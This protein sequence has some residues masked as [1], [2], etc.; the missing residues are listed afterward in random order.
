MK[1][2]NPNI[3]NGVHTI[4][5]TLQQWDYVGHIIQ[6]MYGNCMGRDVLDFEFYDID[7]APD[8]DCKLKY[9]EDYDYFTCVLKNENGDTLK[10]EGDTDE[11]NDMIVG[12]EIIDFCER[13]SEDEQRNPF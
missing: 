1:N 8:N 5:I 2:Y 6:K 10:C 9:H 7:D 12:I 13:K 11:M 3:E 4:R